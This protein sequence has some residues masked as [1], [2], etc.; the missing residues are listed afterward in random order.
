MTGTRF[1]LSFTLLVAGNAGALAQRVPIAQQLV[2]TP[3]HA[4]G[5]YEIGETV[6]WS[7]APGPVTPPYAYKWTIRRNNA[8]GLKE[9]K[10]DLASGKGI[11]RKPRRGTA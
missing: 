6:G 8:V 2:F 7:V 11:T 4:T 3:Y 1:C 10:L 5:I 9:G